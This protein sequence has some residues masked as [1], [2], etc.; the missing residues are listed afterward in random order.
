MKRGVGLTVNIDISKVRQN[1]RGD[2]VIQIYQ[3]QEC[4]DYPIIAEIEGWG[5]QKYDHNGFVLGG[6]FNDP[7]DLVESGGTEEG[8]LAFRPDGTIEGEPQPTE[9]EAKRLDKSF[10]CGTIYRKVTWEW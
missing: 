3:A 2:K 4:S 5:W 10:K 9:Y 6:C 8:W 1:R 7:K